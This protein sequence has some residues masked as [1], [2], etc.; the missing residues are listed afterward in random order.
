MSHWYRGRWSDV[1]RD[2]PTIPGQVRPSAAIKARGRT[3]HTGVIGTGGYEYGA[4]RLARSVLRVRSMHRRAIHPTQNP[5][6]LLDPLIRYGCPPGGLVI[7]PCAGSAS[8]GVAAR[9][10]GRRALLVEADEA[11]C[12]AAARRLADPQQLGLDAG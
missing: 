5:V 3:P 2:V 6:G 4:T 7:D 9:A 8:T 1:Y 11:M 12:E 10:A